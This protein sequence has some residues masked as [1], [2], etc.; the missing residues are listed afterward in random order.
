[1][2]NNQRKFKASHEKDVSNETIRLLKAQED[3]AKFTKELMEPLW[4]TAR[5]TRALAIITF[6]IAL[7]ALSD[8]LAVWG[9][10]LY[11]AMS[12]QGQAEIIQT[13]IQ[14][15]SFTKYGRG[16]NCM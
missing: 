10:N 12:G 7:F 13:G 8:N 11:V 2:T 3:L 5:S 1:M 16:P 9:Q 15:P 14:D 6:F 4:V